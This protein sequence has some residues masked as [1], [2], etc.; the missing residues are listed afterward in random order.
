MDDERA[1][2]RN[3]VGTFRRCY[4]IQ[5]SAFSLPGSNS[6]IG[7]PGIT[8]EI[9]CLYT[10]WECASRRS[11]TQIIKPSNDP[12][13]LYPVDEKDCDR[14]LILPDMVQEHVLDVLR[15]FRCHGYSPIISWSRMGRLAPIKQI[16]GRGCGV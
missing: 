11:N 6:W 1:A 16:L 4:P 2:D 8:V 13:Q 10:S 15:L 3:T 14:R 7:C 12:L 9:A 5:D